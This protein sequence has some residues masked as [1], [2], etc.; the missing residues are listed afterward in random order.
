MHFSQIFPL[1]VYGNSKLPWQPNQ[2][3]DFLKKKYTKFVKANMKK[4][5]QSL[6]PI[7]H[8][9]SEEIIFKYFFSCIL[10]S[11]VTNENDQKA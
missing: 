10:V 11:M 5:I 3:D 6:S 7:E 4:N 2:R 9:G 1:Y 8:M